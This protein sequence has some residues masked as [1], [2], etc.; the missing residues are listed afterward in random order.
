MSCASASAPFD[1][2]ILAR[3]Q[4]I[5]LFLIF[6]LHLHLHLFLQPK[7]ESYLD[8]QKYSAHLLEVWDPGVGACVGLGGSLGDFIEESITNS[9]W[10]RVRDVVR[11]RARS[12]LT[13]VLACEERG[14][15]AKDD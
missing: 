13:S 1:G 12:L 10:V 15:C 9:Y 5:H 2:S 11:I 3:F 6:L 14:A 7:R 4:L 8:R